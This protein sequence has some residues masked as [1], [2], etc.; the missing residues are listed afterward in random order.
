MPKESGL[1][2]IGWNCLVLGDHQP[3]EFDGGHWVSGPREEY[4]IDIVLGLEKLASIYKVVVEVDEQFV[5]SKIEIC[6]GLGDNTLERNYKNARLAEFTEPVTMDFDG[7]QRIASRLEAKEAFMDSSG[8]YLWIIV[9]EPDDLVSN[10]QK[11]VGIKK[12]TILGYPL[13]D[14][15]VATLNP[16]SKSGKEGKR[17]SSASSR[18]S[19]ASAQV[20]NPPP[21]R[22]SYSGD[23]MYTGNNALGGDPLTTVRLVK[24]V[25]KEKMEKADEDDREVESTVCKRATQRL[26]EY[27]KMLEELSQRRSNA[28]VHNETQQV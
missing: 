27:E 2:E 1:V 3:Q 25:L 26:A 23:G 19:S 24:K 17:K 14:S 6:L 13:L 11:K 28:L 9:H 21:G 20:K 4:P 5:P 12:V 22:Y 8:Q 15:E 10:K 7:K 18:A 16:K